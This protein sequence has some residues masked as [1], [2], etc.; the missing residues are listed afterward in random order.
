MEREQPEKTRSDEGPQNIEEFLDI[1][2]PSDDNDSKAGA[3]VAIF[4]CH[5]EDGPDKKRKAKER[6]CVC[7]EDGYLSRHKTYTT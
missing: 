1:V 3:D 4:L 6:K 2:L 7:C 5:P